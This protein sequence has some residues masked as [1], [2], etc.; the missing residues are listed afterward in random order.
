VARAQRPLSATCESCRHRA[1]RRIWQD[2]SRWPKAADSR[3]RC[4]LTATAN[5]SG[6]GSIPRIKNRRAINALVGFR[7]LPVRQEIFRKV[8][9]FAS[10]KMTQYQSVTSSVLNPCSPEVWRKTAG[11]KKFWVSAG[12][13]Q[14]GGLRAKVRVYWG[15]LQARKPEEIV[16]RGQTGG[17]RGTEIQHSP[18]AGMPQLTVR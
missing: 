18:M 15:F 2:R 12:A 7:L 8:R 3:T 4:V 11:E 16:G 14:S 6:T 10:R 5:D 17:A 9:R 1:R 13:W